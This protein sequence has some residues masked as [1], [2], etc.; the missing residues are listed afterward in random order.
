M[1]CNEGGLNT[2]KPLP[3]GIPLGCPDRHA[4]SDALFR[5]PI[6]GLAGEPERGR[7]VG[8]IDGPQGR[9]Q[10]L[11]RL[12]AAGLGVALLL[13]LGSCG[14]GGEDEAVAEPR[15]SLAVTVAPVTQVSLPQTVDVS[16]T[17][18][19]WEEVP[20]GAE[21]G[22]LTAVNVLVDEGDY[23]RRGQVL[24]QLN[25]TLLRAQLRQQDAAVASAE[26]TLAEADAALAR[27]RELRERGF[28]AQAG[29]DSALARQQTAAANL[30]A[31]R[32]ARAETAAR[33]DQAQIRAP[34]AGL[35][36]SRS[37]TRGQIVQPGVELFRMVRDGRLEVDARV[38]EAQL[39]LVR[40]GQSATVTAPEVGERTG[41]VRIVTPEVSPDTRLGVA[42]IALG[43][44]S[45]FRPGMFARVV[46]D[47][48]TQ[49]GLTVP[50]PAVVYRENQAGLYVVGANNVVSFRPVQVGGRAGDRITVTGELRAG[51]RVAVDGAGF[52]GEGDRVRVSAPPPPQGRIRRAETA[53]E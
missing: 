40:P 35:I 21:T 3:P 2:P 16:G 4:A 23:V 1:H 31:A 28:L 20:I 14:H 43:P 22:G 30:A 17:V 48:G 18:S 52:L 27:A 42:R 6:R 19:P 5:R 12:G 33:V 29:L 39:A 7:D 9:V 34:V 45:G 38:P 51:E 10:A 46:I 37:V 11:S 13:A 47:V 41:T 25:D 24:V 32:A 53:G 49:P 15:A 26:A 8:R 50:A 44:S 36:I